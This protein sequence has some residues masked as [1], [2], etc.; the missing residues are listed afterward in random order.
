MLFVLRRAS[1][2]TGCNARRAQK[3]GRSG[4]RPTRPR[5]HREDSRHDDAESALYLKDPGPREYQQRTKRYWM[6]LE[7]RQ[8]R[9][10]R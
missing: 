9:T 5:W 2:Q 7:A 1:P 6:R 8:Y 3:K 10:S 4:T